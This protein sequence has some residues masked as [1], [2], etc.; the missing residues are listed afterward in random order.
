MPAHVNIKGFLSTH[1]REAPYHRSEL[2]ASLA[3]E[4]ERRALLAAPLQLLPRTP[5]APKPLPL[6]LRLNSAQLEELRETERLAERAITQK[7]KSDHLK[8]IRA[9][10]R[11]AAAQKEAAADAA[12]AA[13]AAQAWH[14]NCRPGG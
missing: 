3:T 11:E 12:D 4:E 1:F 10:A 9:A 7:A 2:L 5:G 13:R 6:Q 8:S 14:L